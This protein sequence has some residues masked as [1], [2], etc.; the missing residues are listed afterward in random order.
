[1]FG[2]KM[3]WTKRKE[4]IAAEKAVRAREVERQRLDH[5]DW[6]ARRGRGAVISA[7][8]AVSDSNTYRDDSGLIPAI[9]ATQ[10]FAERT[11]YSQPVE[12]TPASMSGGGGSFDGGGSSGDWSGSSSS[13]DSGSSSSD[14]YSSS[15]DSSSFS[16]SD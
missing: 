2:I 3:P 5:L 14:S 10:L 15:S 4:R 7:R 8:P 16:S 1:M 9:L 13:S 12:Y 11:N 6:T